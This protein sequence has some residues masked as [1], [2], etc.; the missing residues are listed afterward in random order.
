MT[1]GAAAE[2]ADAGGSA[3]ANA[4]I[5]D[6]F[7]GAGIFQLAIGS[8]V[9]LENNGSLSFVADAAATGGATALA[10]A[11]VD[12]V[13]Q[14]ALATDTAAVSFVNSGSVLA[15]AGALANG[16]SA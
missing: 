14:V 11:S 16:N 5:G 7:A 15:D 6:P 8:T 3:L 4:D 12:A 9:T 13:D 2:A 10:Y 1:V